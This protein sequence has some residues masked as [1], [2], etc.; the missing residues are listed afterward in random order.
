MVKM[1]LWIVAIGVLAA[2]G[3]WWGTRAGIPGQDGAI[4][5]RAGAS[6]RHEVGHA[7]NSGTLKTKAMHRELDSTRYTHSPY[8]LQEFMLPAVTIGGLT[9][10]EALRKLMA[11]YRDACGKCGE[12]P[13]P[14]IFSKP[15]GA[16]RKLTMNLPA[17]NFK[18]S[19]QLLASLAG[20]KVSRKDMDFRFEPMANERKSV[21][22]SLQVSPS[23]LT[24]INVLAGVV[25]ASAKD[26]QDPNVY[27]SIQ[28]CLEKLGLTD[29]S[30]HVSLGVS[31]ELTVET[32]STRDAAVI[33]ELARSIGEQAPAQVKTEAKIVEI[34]VGSNWTPPDAAQMT[35]GQIEMMMRDFSQQNGV[36]L[37]TLP[38]VTARNGQNAAVELV[39]EFIYPTDESGKAFESRNVGKALHVQGNLLG[40]GHEVDLKFTDTTVVIDPET[41]RPDFENHTDMAD[42]SYLGDG[43]TKLVV[44]TRADG[45]R[46]L[47]FLKA[48][49][50]D[51]SGQPIH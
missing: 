42:K 17:G 41:G 2:I 15:P 19:V 28:D 38:S 43:G 8:R 20:M 36:E 24:D 7:E 33:S 14:L 40:F 18:T 49:M 12:I 37:Q 35:D 46:T 3:L 25:P 48:R 32:M 23:F 27:K 44:Q 30:T 39:R 13:L 31:G 16:T 51:A 45:S 6:S 11:S 4:E 22:R 29:S 34:P 5:S 9:L 10:D 50:I 1:R 47:M 26:S 21:N